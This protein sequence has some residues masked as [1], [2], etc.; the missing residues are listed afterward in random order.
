MAKT[1]ATIN[2]GAVTEE[3]RTW[4]TNGIEKL[5]A[6]YVE[7][8]KQMLSQQYIARETIT[9]FFDEVNASGILKKRILVVFKPDN[10][11]DVRSLSIFFSEAYKEMMNEVNTQKTREIQE[12]KA[13]AEHT[14]ED[15]KRVA[16]LDKS[17]PFILRFKQNVAA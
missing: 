3:N 10:S 6:G 1:T 7:R 12:I 16:E 11:I 13:K 14:I 2:F 9:A 17:N 15:I 8:F 5:L 4:V